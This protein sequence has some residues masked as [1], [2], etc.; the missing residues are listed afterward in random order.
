[1]PTDKL[2]LPRCSRSTVGHLSN[3]ST[4]WGARWYPQPDAPASRLAENLDT[5]S[6]WVAR[7]LCARAVARAASAN[8][9]RSASAVRCAARRRHPAL[10]GSTNCHLEVGASTS[11]SLTLSVQAYTNLRRFHVCSIVALVGPW[12]S[13]QHI[14]QSSKPATSLLYGAALA[15]ASQAQLAAHKRKQPCTHRQPAMS[16]SVACAHVQ[17]A[18]GCRTCQDSSGRKPVAANARST[19]ESASGTYVVL[20]LAVQLVGHNTFAKQAGYHEVMCLGGVSISQ[21]A[22]LC[23][24]L[25]PRVV[26]PARV[27]PSQWRPSAFACASVP[28]T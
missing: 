28:A 26:S 17:R 15:V 27:R 3:R 2:S 18:A 20:W 4:V 14:N 9:N 1:M 11:T 7:R 12:P 24:A 13:V 19:H 5:W 10:A 22:L 25:V 8:A 16:R 23:D 6:P 21:V